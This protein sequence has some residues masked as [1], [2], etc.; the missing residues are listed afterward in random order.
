MKFK[1]YLEQIEHVEIYP[2]ISLLLFSTIFATII[3]Y[4]FTADRRSMQEHAEIPLD[5][6]D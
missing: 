4:V 3:L 2:L 5:G 1:T 6:Q